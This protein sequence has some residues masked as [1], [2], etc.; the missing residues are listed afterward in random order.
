MLE[1]PLRSKV[2]Y[3][4][5][6][7]TTLVDLALIF[8]HFP[9]T[10]QPQLR[11]FGQAHLWCSINPMQPRWGLLLAGL[12]LLSRDCGSGLSEPSFPL[13]CSVNEVAFVYS[14]WL[15]ETASVSFLSL[16]LFLFL[17]FSVCLSVLLSLSLSHC[18][19]LNFCLSLSLSVILS[20]IQASKY[21]IQLRHNSSSV[22]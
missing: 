4:Q 5:S 9:T 20:L 12:L 3:L 15:E 8:S 6:L 16:S 10:A 21:P 1:T 22:Q 14:Q 7:K 18:L 17:L 2:K 11:R 19:S 13:S